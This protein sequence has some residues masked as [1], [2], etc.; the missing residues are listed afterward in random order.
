[1][2]VAVTRRIVPVS[3]AY[4]EQRF[5][6]RI[7]GKRFATPLFLVLIIVE[8]TDVV[9]AVDSIPAIFGITRDPFLIFTSNV[10]AIMGLRSLYF[11]LASLLDKFHYLHYSLAAIL[12]GV[13]VKMLVEN[14]HHARALMKW[15]PES[16]HGALDWLPQHAIHVPTAFSLGAICGSLLLGVLASLLYA[17]NHPGKDQAAP[18]PGLHAQPSAGDSGAGEPGRDSPPSA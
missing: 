16:T 9:F 13:G 17:Q 1:M 2:S 11:A 5:F 15:L 10:F 18:A 4:H 8:V 7:D 14:A 6:T 3:D 12:S